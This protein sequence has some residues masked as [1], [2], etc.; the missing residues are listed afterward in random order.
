MFGEYSNSLKIHER[1]YNKL[2]KRIYELEY[3]VLFSCFCVN[4]YL[5]IS[6]CI[7]VNLNFI[8]TII[9]VFVFVNIRQCI[10]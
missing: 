9:R 6:Y 10:L 4:E 3:N 2:Y 5:F 1:K 8:Y 7:S